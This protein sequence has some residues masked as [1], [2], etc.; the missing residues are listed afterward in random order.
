MRP[1]PGIAV[2]AKNC[3][4]PQDIVIP[5]TIREDLL[6]REVLEGPLQELRQVEE[7]FRGQ[8]RNLNFTYEQ[9]ML[10]S[11]IKKAETESVEVSL[12]QYMTE[13]HTRIQ[14]CP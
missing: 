5:G 10:Q 7:L 1:N 9:T 12:M 14:I 3:N 6:D 13:L 11:L 2:S 8:I 4:V